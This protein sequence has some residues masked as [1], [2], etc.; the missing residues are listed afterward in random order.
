MENHDYDKQPVLSTPRAKNVV[1]FDPQENRA[2]GGQRWGTEKHNAAQV[3]GT[4]AIQYLGQSTFTLGAGFPGTA[5]TKQINKTFDTSEGSSGSDIQDNAVNGWDEH[6]GSS[7]TL[8]PNTNTKCPSSLNNFTITNGVARGAFN[9]SADVADPNGVFQYSS[10][11]KAEIN[12][13]T[14]DTI[15]RGRLLV[16]LYDWPDVA[17]NNNS[18][19]EYLPDIE[20]RLKVKLTTLDDTDTDRI[21]DTYIGGIAFR[22]K[23]DSADPP[24]SADPV[25]VNNVSEFFIYAWLRPAAPDGSTEFQSP[26]LGVWR[27]LE[28]AAGSGS[29][30]TNMKLQSPNVNTL[31]GTG[32]TDEHRME[33]RISGDQCVCLWDG[34]VI[35][36]FFLDAATG[37]SNE[38]AGMFDAHIKATG[39]S[40]ASRHCT[41]DDYIFEDLVSE[42]VEIGT[43]TNGV[44]LKTETNWEEYSTAANHD[45]IAQ[46]GALDVVM[47]NAGSGAASEEWSKVA[48][49]SL[50]LVTDTIATTGAYEYLNDKAIID[51]A[52]NDE[53]FG[54]AYCLVGQTPHPG[55]SESPSIEEYQIEVKLTPAD[56]TNAAHDDDSIMSGIAFMID[57]TSG[58]PTISS[59][60]LKMWVFAWYRPP[61]PTNGGAQANAYLG[62]WEFKEGAGSTL[63]MTHF[64]NTAGTNAGVIPY[65]LGNEGDTN[66]HQMVIK[67]RNN[68]C[69]CEWD[70]Q[71]IFTNQFLSDTYG[72]AGSKSGLYHSHIKHDDGNV[73]ATLMPT[74]DDYRASSV[75]TFDAALRQ[76]LIT[77]SAG[78]VKVLSRTGNYNTIIDGAASTTTGLDATVNVV[79]GV[80]FNQKHY[81]VDSL[82]YRYYDLVLGQLID[83]NATTAGTLPGEDQNASPGFGA[84]TATPDGIPRANLIALYGG[85]IVLNDPGSPQNLYMARINDPFDWDTS[86]FSDSDNQAAVVFGSSEMGLIG[87]TITSLAPYSDQ[88]MAIGC[89]HELYVL[90]GDPGFGGALNNVSRKVG[91]VSGDAMVYGPDK[92]LYFI[93]E[94]GLYRI[95]PNQYNID[96]SNR[97]SRGKLDKTFMKLDAEKNR[98][99]LLWDVELDGL[100]IFITP[101]A[102]GATQHWFWDLRTESFQP[103]VLPDTSGPTAVMEFK[104]KTSDERHVLM[105]TRAGYVI[106]FNK[107]IKDDDGGASSAVAIDSHVLIGPINPF[108]DEGLMCDFDAIEVNLDEQ[109][110]DVQ[111]DILVGDTVE[112]ALASTPFNLGTASAGRNNRFMNRASG[113]AAFLRLSNNTASQTWQQGSIKAWVSPG[114]EARS[115]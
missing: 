44:K 34:D 72:G 45:G 97:I 48:G 46:A 47:P 57:D 109:S 96:F 51:D 41:F 11:E 21:N 33:I 83:W 14:D 70:G 15:S 92:T 27:F 108:A 103:Q 66:E 25:N 112:G 64:N 111:V 1:P 13:T 95:A 29:S 32:D 69:W 85:R 4:K 91:V 107:D 60:F 58:D 19:Q 87:D 38:F 26:V 73:R 80:F 65:N 63:T 59:A 53:G 3:N 115:A 56:M 105:G 86:V 104:S 110:D 42:I 18:V 61:P 2:R 71:P 82:N 30:I 62:V 89:Q 78:A 100:W 106:R 24:V 75:Q 12:E 6:Q 50:A 113:Y 93:S 88:A 7:N 5:F 79:R 74:F 37:A 94:T 10:G 40:K 76:E 8:L 54:Y 101:F 77:V 81:L 16:N 98:I 28:F 35:F 90:V 9:V 55:F 49:A 22:I 114:A 68:T 102:T 20:Y 84:N 36:D 67:I 52:T 31:V 17:T 43:G 23:A 39:V 99:Q